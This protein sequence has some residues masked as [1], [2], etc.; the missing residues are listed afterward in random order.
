M[1]KIQLTV[2]M[3]VKVFCD[4]KIK[5]FYLPVYPLYNDYINH[6]ILFHS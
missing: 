6:K 4:L 5:T 3:Q 1:D 2:V